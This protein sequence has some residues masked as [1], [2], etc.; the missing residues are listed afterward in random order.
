[1]PKVASEWCPL[2]ARFSVP[3][4]DPSERGATGHGRVQGRLTSDT[5]AYWPTAS[6]LHGIMT[7]LA[8]ER[9]GL[10]CNPIGSRKSGFSP[11]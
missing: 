8:N 7:A 1:M 5:S 6:S 3:Q 9:L 10:H 4:G 11:T 2:S